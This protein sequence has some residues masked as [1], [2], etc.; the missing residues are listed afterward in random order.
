MGTLQPD[1]GVFRS[2]RTENVE[3]GVG[4]DLVLLGTTGML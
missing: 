4:V 3:T 1:E 2:V